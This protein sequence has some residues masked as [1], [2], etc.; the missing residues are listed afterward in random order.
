MA[1][2]RDK[3]NNFFEETQKAQQDAEK[4]SE[5]ARFINDVAAP[6][7]EQLREEL[8][9]HGR[10]V[11]IRNTVTSAAIIVQY[12]GEEELNYRIQGRTFPNG[13]LPFAEIRFKERKGLRLIRVESMFRSGSP[14]YRIEDVTA[15]EIIQNFLQH[16]MRRADAG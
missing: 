5:M 7:F 8:Q 15:D 4:G 2:W 10:S 16:Y 13:V 3:L 12:G 11:T 1:E 9:N 6:A 14:D